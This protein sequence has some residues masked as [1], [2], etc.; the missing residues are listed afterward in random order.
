MHPANLEARIGTPVAELVSACGGYVANPE[1]LIA[2]GIMTG[3]AI[4]TD[5]VPLTQ[6]M[7]C[8]LAATGADL[9]ARMAPLPCIRCGDCADVCPVGLLPQQ[10]HRGVLAADAAVL[11]R[12]GIDDC[13]E[14][15]CCDYVCPSGI[16][17]TAGFRGARAE[18]RRQ[19][20]AARR[21]DDARERF[22][23]HQ[24]RLAAAAEQERSA[25]EAA[26]RRARGDD[27]GRGE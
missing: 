14:C 17:L 6:A 23:R 5:E 7:N 3:R 26:R 19:H 11:E 27:V 22:A 9:T 21:A 20:E 10:L 12:H 24:Q 2:G 1:R 8:I 18:A 15:G 25:F 16:A 4:A 13:I